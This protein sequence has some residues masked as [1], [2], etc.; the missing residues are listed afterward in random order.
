MRLDGTNIRVRSSSQTGLWL[1]A[2]LLALLGLC[3]ATQQSAGGQQQKGSFAGNSPLTMEQVVDNLVGMNLRRAQALHS[4][5]GTRTYRVEYRSFRGIVNAEMAVDV[6]Y[7]A[8]DTKEFTIQSSTGS[9]FVIDKVFKKLLEAEEDALSKDAQRSTALS[10]ENYDFTLVGYES[11]ASQ[12]M[13]VL[14]VE[15]RTKSKFLFRGRVWVDA[16]DFAVVRLEAEPAKSPSFWTKKSEIEQSYLKVNDF[17]LPERNHSI[18]FIRLGGRAELTIEYQNYQITAA[19]P[20]GSAPSRE[21][22]Q[23][24]GESRM[25][26]C[27]QISLRR[28]A[29]AE[30]GRSPACSISN[31]HQLPNRS[32]TLAETNAAAAEGISWQ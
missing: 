6:M 9:K 14:I 12:S 31:Q 22:A 32:P 2:C 23:S 1:S 29:Q 13:Y 18:S 30:P 5:K 19:D 10:R 20:V 17:W 26:A 21:V 25:P 15:P 3:A 16:S 27:G 28:T 11:S 24:A 8:P 4:Y 7:V